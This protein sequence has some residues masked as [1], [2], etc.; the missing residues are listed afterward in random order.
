MAAKKTKGKTSS[1]KSTNSAR[2]RSSA[3]RTSQRGAKAQ[4]KRRL[5][6]QIKAIILCAVGILLLALVII[7][8]G[9]LW[10]TMRSFLFGV[11]GVCSILVP[12]VFIY[13]GVM[14]AKE[15]QIQ[16][17]DKVTAKIRKQEYSIGTEQVGGMFNKHDV[18]VV[19]GISPK[20]LERVFQRASINQA[21]KDTVAQAEKTAQKTLQGAQGTIDQAQA[22]LQ[23]QQQRQAELDALE[24]EIKDR[25]NELLQANQKLE[26]SIRAYHNGWTDRDGNQH[27]GIDQLRQDYHSLQSEYKGLQEQETEAM[28]NLKLE[29]NKAEEDLIY[30]KPIVY[31]YGWQDNAA[32]MRFS[33]YYGFGVVDAGE[34]VKA[35]A[36]CDDDPMCVEMGKPAEV[37]TS[38]NESPCSYEEG[39]PG[40]ENQ[41][42]EN[43]IVC[44]FNGF[45]NKDDQKELLGANS[46][47]IDAVAF[48]FSGLSAFRRKS[49]IENNIPFITQK[50][51]FLPFMGT[52]L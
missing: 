42:S 49:L 1:K 28:S 3:S 25:N 38:S 5:N 16:G 9:A 47:T 37:Y 12:M 35:A 43:N 21:A 14:T 40:S 30:N 27:E 7:P 45:K 6:P 32:G 17:L 36:K 52:F 22:I 44:T 23:G 24:R 2:S 10:K 33:C 39:V 50:Q 51:A 29:T 26:R 15:K 18:T 8:G 19:E 46:L 48:E 31:D 13:L 11:F 34:L 4:P 20:E 41:I